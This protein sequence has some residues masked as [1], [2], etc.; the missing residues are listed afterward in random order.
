M[1]RTLTLKSEMGF[2]QYPR[3]TVAQVLQIKQAPY[4]KWCYYCLSNI[5]FQP[6][7]LE[8]IGVTY[9]IQKPGVN[10]QFYDTE[11]AALRAAR[12]KKEQKVLTVQQA[13][14][15]KH[16][17]NR[18]KNGKSYSVDKLNGKTKAALRDQNNHSF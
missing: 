4:L 2:G 18:R 5:T 8:T 11:Q 15:Y 10:K 14:I 3:F 7:I 17:G 1:L 12:P 16:K 13:S 9:L 6:E